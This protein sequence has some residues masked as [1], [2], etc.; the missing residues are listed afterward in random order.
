M[1]Y[2]SLSS[3]SSCTGFAKSFFIKSEMHVQGDGSN[4]SDG[5]V[6]RGSSAEVSQEQQQDERRQ[7]GGARQAQD[8]RRSN[9]A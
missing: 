2:I 9:A 8:A 5:V 7:E 6:E 3:Q 4:S 1:S